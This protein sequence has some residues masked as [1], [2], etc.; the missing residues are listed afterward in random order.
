MPRSDGRVRPGQK[1]DTAFSARAWNRAQDAADVVLGDTRSYLPGQKS[2]G[3]TNVIL[4]EAPGVIPG[5]W[6]FF[7]PSGPGP[8]DV[9]QVSA[10]IAFKRAEFFAKPVAAG[11]TASP[12]ASVN[13]Y[14]NQHI[15]MALGRTGQ[16]LLKVQVSGAVSC[17]IRLRHRLHGFAR[18]APTVAFSG[19][20]A[21]SSSSIATPIS[22]LCGPM[23]IVWFD[24]SL[25]VSPSSNANITGVDVPAIV[26]L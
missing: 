9:R 22:G 23:R 14:A 6:V 19:S 15:G 5:Q 21:F 20:T 16:G 7:Y 25:Y 2:V 13:P 18:F 26:S 10:D 3:D 12:T 11:A 17:W 24:D 4:A 8:I 1:I